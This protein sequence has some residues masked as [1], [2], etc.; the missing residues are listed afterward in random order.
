MQRQAFFALVIVVLVG[1]CLV[2]CGLG[3]QPADIASGCS[4]EAWDVAVLG[5]Y[6]YLATPKGLCIVD[7]YDPAQPVR[8]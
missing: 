7:V 8:P 6:A 4:A 2:G 1:Q 3:E 5:D